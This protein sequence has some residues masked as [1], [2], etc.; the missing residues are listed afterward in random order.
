MKHCN[1]CDTTKTL[2]CF[3]KHSSKKDGLRTVCKH[4][5]KNYDQT[6]RSSNIER[7]KANDAKWAKE[8]RGMA[9]AKCAKRR[10]G[11]M[12]RTPSWCDTQAIKDLYLE[13][14]K[15]EMITGDSY[16][17]DHIIP[18]QGKLVS[19]LHIPAN[20]QI[21]TAKENFKKSNTFNV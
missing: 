17:V 8:N 20:L 11:K 7:A 10:S 21:I 15:L 2:D 3:A 1:K 9:N 4:C 12:Q 19:G 18:L 6:W 14:K 5:N 16:H 13:A